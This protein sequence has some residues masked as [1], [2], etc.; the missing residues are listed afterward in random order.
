MI[1]PSARAGASGR[2]TG[3][4]RSSVQHEL[5]PRVSLDVGYYRRVFGNFTV[6]DNLDITPADYT[7]FCITAPNDPRLGSVSASQVCGLADISQAKA[8]VAGTPSNQIIRFA[9][10][11]GGERSQVYDGI[12][13]TV[14]ARPNGRLFLQA[15]VSTGR[16][17]TKT[18]S[19][20]D[21]PQT[22]RFCEVQEPFLP[23]YRVSGGYT[24]PYQIAGERCVPE[25]WPAAAAVTSRHA[26][27]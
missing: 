4:T 19:V 25:H 15:G 6:T 9:S 1:R 10:E 7:S 2:T 13:F 14:N 5:M 8:G 17:V 20:V 12:D 22:L 11:Y 27:R 23:N 3:S 26:R 24:F 18:C 16:T 21:N